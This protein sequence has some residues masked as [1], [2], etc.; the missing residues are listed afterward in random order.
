MVTFSLLPAL[1][2]LAALEGILTATGVVPLSVSQD[3]FVGFASSRPL[4]V[5]EDEADGPVWMTTAP[6]RLVYFNSQRFLKQKPP[7]ARRVFCMGGS[8]T[9]GRPYDDH[10]SFAGWLRELLPELCPKAAWEVINAGGISY[11][12]YRVAA[13][14]K[15]LARYEPDL[16]IVYTGHN[17]FLE[18]RTYPNRQAAPPA[19]LRAHA[20]LARTRTYSL[21]H[22]IIRPTPA[23]AGRSLL[24]GEVDAVLDHTVG[25]SSYH[26]DEPLRRQILHHFELN[27]DRMVRLA[28]ACGASIA[29]ITPASNLK[30]CSPFK[31]QHADGLEPERLEQW[32]ALYER[33]KRCQEAGQLAEALTAYE[34]AAEID[35]RFADLH[36]R[37]GS[38]LFE[39]QRFGAASEAYRRAL[40]EDVCPLRALGEIVEAIRRTGE[41]L[42]VPVIDFAAALTADCRRDHGHDV[43]GKEYFLDHV[44]LKI[45]VTRRLAATIAGELVAP[46]VPLTGQLLTR[47]TQRIEARI[48][49]H[50]HAT[51]LRN[52]AKVLTWAGKRSEA[53]PLAQRALEVLPDDV[54][55]LCMAASYE[56]G[57]GLPDL[58]V[59]RCRK[60]VQLDPNCADGHQLLGAALYELGELEEACDHFMEVQR[61]QPRDANAYYIAAGI[62]CELGRQAEAIGH[63]RDAVRFAPD[64]PPIRRDLA[65][66]LAKL[67]QRKE[68]VSTYRQAIELDPSDAA[69]H[70][71]VGE[72]L[73]ADEK[74]REALS[75]FRQALRVDPGRR[76]TARS[77]LEAQLKT[78]A[79]SG[80]AQLPKS[81]D[82]APYVVQIQKG[83]QTQYIVVLPGSGETIVIDHGDTRPHRRQDNSSLE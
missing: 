39:M 67:G 15:E 53:G 29:F 1:V 77:F 28:R 2:L 24:Y 75:H 14:I 69:A 81:K 11:A 30:D 6:N 79:T 78:A 36:Y 3:P 12:S 44:H 18:E 63:Y 7:G 57:R 10:T 46:D 72:L 76:D 23:A 13:L 40:D 61:L 59:G 51:A 47:V 34:T 33:G 4:Y 66:T 43:P 17:E 62:L 22:T 8:T 56:T 38:V 80:A 70:N 32:T 37:I 60:V 54:E 20:L 25:P 55:A 52:L 48:D 41:R 9:F 50:A 68:A 42:R 74:P 73:L 83:D 82:D 31:S 16:F 71:A 35:R 49:A 45:S 21:L 58:A 26:R 27:L 65:A 64:D 19:R 5:E